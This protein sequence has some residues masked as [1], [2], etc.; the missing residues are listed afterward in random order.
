MDTLPTFELGHLIVAGTRVLTHTTGRA[1][2]DEDI[3]ELLNMPSEEVLLWVRGLERH[4]VVK[5]V[6]TPFDQRVDIID[7]TLLETLPRSHDPNVLKEEIE[8]FQER[9][10]EHHD[11]L[12][13]L[14]GE[15]PSAKVKA[16]NTKLS[17]ELERFK[18]GGRPRSPFESD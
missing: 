18:K 8:A 11:Q 3:A 10:E 7:H 4:G 12:E 6:K 15:D 1:P 2:T 9:T 5:L 16:K 17:E 14:L 13:K